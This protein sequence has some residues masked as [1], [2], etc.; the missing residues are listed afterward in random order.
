MTVTALFRELDA[1]ANA[2]WDAAA[3]VAQ[4]D[5]TEDLIAAQA[6][7]ALAEDRLEAIEKKLLQA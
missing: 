6:E 3:A 1:A 7:L 4:A 2:L 5:T